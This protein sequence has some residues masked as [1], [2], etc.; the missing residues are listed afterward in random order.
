MSQEIER[1]K[2]TY[3]LHALILDR[4]PELFICEEEF[5]NF[6]QAKICLNSALALEEN[7][8]L[9]LNNYREL[10]LEVISAAV[11]DM[12]ERSYEYEDFF[13]IRTTINRR[14]VNLLSTTRT[15]LD[16]YSQSLRK[17]GVT[18]EKIKAICSKAYDD[19]FEYRFM[20]ALRN[21]AQHEGLAVHGVTAGGHWLP[22]QNPKQLQFYIEPY[23]LKTEL[24][25][26]KFK[27]SV[28]DESPEK[29]ALLPAVRVYIGAISSI[30]KNIRELIAPFVEEA[31][32]LF[33]EAI[34][35]HHS[36]AQ[37]QYQGLAA[38]VKED[39]TVIEKVPIFLHW[40]DV[41]QRLLK[42]N[43]PIENLAER[44]VTNQSREDTNS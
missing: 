22:P 37:R 25:D 38:I 36:E 8:D 34:A 1:A 41:R 3:S 23:A 2:R 43:Y 42:R 9:L 19:F 33:E 44:F 30:H 24:E 39:D 11:N 10:E 21:Y 28:L 7:Y 35:R 14:V 17:I 32:C 27:K 13:K 40:D 12:T 31:R 15:Y 29:V 5:K 4:N 20:E 18:S 16:Q 6:K 26:S